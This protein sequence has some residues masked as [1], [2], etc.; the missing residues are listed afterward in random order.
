M[1]RDILSCL[2]VVNRDVFFFVRNGP[3]YYLLYVWYQKK[4]DVIWFVSEYKT[5]G[6]R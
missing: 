2:N 1:N 6:I 4:A 3:Y 5:R